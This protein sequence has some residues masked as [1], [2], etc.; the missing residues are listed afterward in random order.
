MTCRSEFQ[1]RPRDLFHD[2]ILTFSPSQCPGDLRHELSLLARTLG[3]WVQIP[4][5]A[6]VS[7]LCAYSVFVLFCVGSGLAMDLSPIQGDLQTVYRIKNWK[8]GKGPTKGCRAIIIIIIII[9]IIL[10]FTW[11][12]NDKPVAFGPSLA[13]TE[14][15]ADTSDYRIFQY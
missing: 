14:I 13:P 5:K 6:W 11:G 15:S 7:V 9:I 8:S 2:T 1:I 10:T 4:L 3:S 12:R